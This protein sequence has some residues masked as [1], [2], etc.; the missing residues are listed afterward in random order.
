MDCKVFFF[1]GNLGLQFMY[2]IVGWNN[3]V[4]IFIFYFLL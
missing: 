1:E 4:F 2:I 3:S